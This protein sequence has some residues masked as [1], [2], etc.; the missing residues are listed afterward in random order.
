MSDDRLRQSYDMLLAL[1]VDSAAERTSCPPVERLAGL[2]GR[3]EDE[4]A[5]LALLDH[6]MAC[7][8]CMPEFEL[9]RSAS[10]ASGGH[11]PPPGS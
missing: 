10:R 6:V 11:V 7:P 5:R 3:E 2:I 9:L 8:F 1:R 4:D